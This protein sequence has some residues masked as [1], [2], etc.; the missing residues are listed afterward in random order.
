MIKK[1]DIVC[2]AYVQPFLIHP[3]PSDEL[4][5][6]ADFDESVGN[7]GEFSPEIDLNLVIGGDFEKAPFGKVLDLSD[8]CFYEKILN[9]FSKYD[10]IILDIL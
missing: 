6:F 2:L 4:H 10:T 5:R 9:I 1:Q 7:Q 3:N 8:L